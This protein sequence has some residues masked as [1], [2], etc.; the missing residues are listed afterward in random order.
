MDH[1]EMVEKLRA[2]ANVSYE[3]AKAA[4][5]ASDWDILDALVLLESEGKVKDSEPAK[6]YTTQEKN[7]ET[8]T[9]STA[10]TKSSFADGMEKMWAWLKQAFQKGN[11][12]QFVIN[13]R[14][15]ELI[16]MPITVMALLMICFWPFSMI[17]LF[18][19]LFLGCR[20]SFR[21]PDVGNKVNDMMGRAQEKAASAVEIHL[22]D[23]E[24]KVD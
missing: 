8:W 5:E 10:S 22:N 1:F 23:S 20:Y 17:V 21:G 18:V 13:R 12:N 9:R 14:G 2:K 16:S 6:E 11:H 4:L 24:K 15:D 3:E 19:G 7:E